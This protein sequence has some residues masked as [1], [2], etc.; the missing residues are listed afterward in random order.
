MSYVDTDKNYIV[1]YN[2]SYEGLVQLTVHLTFEEAKK[3][4]DDSDYFP[5]RR[6]YILKLIENE[7]WFISYNATGYDRG[8]G[9]YANA[10]I[11]ISPSEW[12][13][14]IYQNPEITDGPYV[15]LYAEKVDEEMYKW[16]YDNV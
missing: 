1:F 5:N 14:E 16:F 10:V 2:D 8:N 6:K 3:L 15:I 4:R 7:Y 9:L 11:S 12:I 13:E